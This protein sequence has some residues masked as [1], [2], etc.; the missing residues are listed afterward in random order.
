MNTIYRNY[1]IVYFQGKYYVTNISKL[2]HNDLTMI[3]TISKM[4]IRVISRIF[5]I[6][7]YTVV[8]ETL[9]VQTLAGFW[10]FLEIFKK[11]KLVM[12]DVDSMM[13]Y[14]TY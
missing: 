2:Y 3:I 1:F 9:A 10:I 13:L 6:S 4:I 5:T 11:Q 12:Y 14:V 8:G 7:L